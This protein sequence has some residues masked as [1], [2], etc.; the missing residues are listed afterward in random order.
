MADR[1]RM[2]TSFGAAA[3]AYEAGRPGYPLPVVEWMLSLA[4][5]VVSR[6]RVADVGAGTGKLTRAVVEAGAEVVAVDPDADMLTAL[7]GGRAGER[8]GGSRPATGRCAG[9]G[10]EH[11]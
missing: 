8:R 3:D 6:L 4:D 7:Q 5:P 1:D 2:S 9:T 10:M 11:P